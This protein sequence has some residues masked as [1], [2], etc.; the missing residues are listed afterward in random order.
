MVLYTAAQVAGALGVL[1]KPFIPFTSDKICDIFKID[2][3]GWITENIVVKGNTTINKPSLLFQKIDDKL[4]EDQVAKL[5][6]TKSS[7]TDKKYAPMKEEITFD[8]FMKLDIRTG[9]IIAAEK[10]KKA[11]KLLQLTV[12]IGVEKRTIVSGIAE[13]FTPEEVIGKKVSVLINLAPRKLRGVESQGMILMAE[14]ENGKLSFVS[15]N[16]ASA[17]MVIR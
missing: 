4:V 11:D 10:I 2:N 12:D 6:A 5:L 14:N 15:T 8:D 16:E 3:S 1:C 7:S 13:H 17:G 9:E